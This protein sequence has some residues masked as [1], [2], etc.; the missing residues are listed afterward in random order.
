[1]Q[2]R[3]GEAVIARHAVLVEFERLPPGGNVDHAIPLHS[4]A[5]RQDRV[6][7][8]VV[9]G[10]E[11]AAADG[12]LQQS[13]HPER[14]EGPPATSELDSSPSPRLRMT[15]CCFTAAASFRINCGIPSPVTAETS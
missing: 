9:K 13:C 8:T 1:R 14:S 10:I 6:E 4:I 3:H 7:V 11:R 12:N 5:Y 2:Y 15:R